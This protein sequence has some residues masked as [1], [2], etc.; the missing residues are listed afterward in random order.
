V[1]APLARLV[2][3][4]HGST[5]PRWRAPF[6]RLL[7]EVAGVSGP[8]GVRL[9]FMESAEPGLEAVARE[10]AGDG[11]ERLVVLPLFLASGVHVERDVAG[12]AEAIRGAHPGLAVDVLPPVGEDERLLATLREIAVGH[13]RAAA[14]AA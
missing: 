6:E 7:G 8:G 13:A 4:A 5:D 9:A 12:K 10:A 14:G 3:Y 1:A 2:L 11:V